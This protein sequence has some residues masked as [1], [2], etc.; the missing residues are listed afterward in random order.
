M[1]K[2]ESLIEVKENKFQKFLKSIKNYFNK[3]GK[4]KNENQIEK[5]SEEK[6][7]IFYSQM[8]DMDVLEQLVKG[9]IDSS[10]IDPD[11]LE[12]IKAL[13]K[14]REMEIREKIRINN[15]KIAMMNKLILEIREIKN[16]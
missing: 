9:E 3:F 6:K 1:K 11:T 13:C 10:S 5:D 16:S 15:E 2:E 8:N 14:K 7:K 4:N 12:R